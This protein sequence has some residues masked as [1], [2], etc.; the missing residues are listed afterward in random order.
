MGAIPTLNS[1]HCSHR[2]ICLGRSDASAA[3][4]RICRQPCTERSDRYVYGI[5]FS[6]GCDRFFS[7]GVVADW[8]RTTYL[9][10]NPAMMWYIVAGI[11]FVST[12]LMIAV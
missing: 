10:S 1:D 6:A 11:G 5:C 3:I 12:L 2:H 7:A 4:L 9:D 8:L